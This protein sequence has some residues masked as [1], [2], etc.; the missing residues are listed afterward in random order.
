MFIENL[1]T[2]FLL[3]QKKKEKNE[4]RDQKGTRIDDMNKEKGVKTFRRVA[5]FHR[6]FE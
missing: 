4:K 5:A 6:K 3:N 1:T 2:I